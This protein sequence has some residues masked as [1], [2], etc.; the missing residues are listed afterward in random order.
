MQIYFFVAEVDFENFVKVN[1]ST[2]VFQNV[3]KC[4]FLLMSAFSAFFFISFF[5]AVEKLKQAALTLV[6]CFCFKF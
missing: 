5:N 3:Q 4:S 6:K 1:G 2:Y